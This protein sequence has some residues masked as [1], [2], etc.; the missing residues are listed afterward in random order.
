MK[1]IDGAAEDFKNARV[2][3]VTTYGTRG[4]QFTRPMTNYNE[5]PYGNL[6]FAT[7]RQTNKVEHIAKDCN[8]KVMFPSSREGEVYEISGTA[9][10]GTDAE[11]REKWRWWTLFWHPEYKK[12]PWF[13]EGSHLHE[14][15]II[16][17]CPTDIK[18]VK[19]KKIDFSVRP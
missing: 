11:I 16:N 14:R 2:V 5:D 6:W 13:T 12:Y 9:A 17:V 18:V 15:A 3:Y 8:V 10:L 19:D 7:F 4:K 1:K